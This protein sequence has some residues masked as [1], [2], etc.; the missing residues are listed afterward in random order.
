MQYHIHIP[1]FAVVVVIIA[2]CS[3]ELLVA[4]GEEWKMPGALYA[5]DD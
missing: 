2:V 3:W 1:A 4:A 5:G